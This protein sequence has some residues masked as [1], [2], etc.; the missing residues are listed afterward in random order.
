MLRPA[1]EAWVRRAQEIPLGPPL[2][3]EDVAKLSRLLESDEGFRKRFDA[4]P[5]AAAEFAGLSGLAAQLRREMRELVAFAERIASDSAYR[6]ELE[7]DPESVLVAAGVPGESAEPLLRALDLPE[8]LF[9]KLEVCAHRQEGLSLKERL[10]MLLLG[11][12]ALDQAIRAA[13]RL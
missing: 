4:D 12:S 13:T 1:P 10:V 5:V 6:E 2:G 7:G 11:T 8:E 3:D 9:E